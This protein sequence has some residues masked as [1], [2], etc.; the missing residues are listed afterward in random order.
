MTFQTNW[1]W[2]LKQMEDIKDILKSQAIYIIDIEVSTPEED[3]KQSTDLKI[4]IT[5]GDIAVRIRRDIP[6]RELTIRAFSGGNKTEI[7]KLRAG[8]GDW[9]LYLWTVK[10]KISEWIL[11]D[12]NKMREAGLLSEQ[13]PIIMNK[14]GY[15][16]FVKYTIPE[17]EYHGCLVARNNNDKIEP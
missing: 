16:G 6:W 15:T 17:L 10:N 11:V 13:R 14:D 8:Y 9:Y 2:Q 4:T 5:T 7:H 3:M 12:I 1:D